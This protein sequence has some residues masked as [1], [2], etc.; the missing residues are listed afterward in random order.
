MWV[1]EG[2][3]PFVVDGFQKVYSLLMYLPVD[4]RYSSFLVQD[5]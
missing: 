1:W 4:A 2:F 3:S 5:A